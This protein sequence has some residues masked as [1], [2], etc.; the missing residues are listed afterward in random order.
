VAHAAGAQ[1]AQRPVPAEEEVVRGR[2]RGH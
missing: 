1:G 2:G